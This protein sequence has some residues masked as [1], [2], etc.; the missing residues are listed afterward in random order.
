MARKM[1]TMTRN[2]DEQTSTVIRKYAVS[3]VTGAP[4]IRFPCPSKDLLRKTSVCVFCPGTGH[5]A[6]ATGESPPVL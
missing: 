4:S 3:L 6:S 2:I 5:L 1:I